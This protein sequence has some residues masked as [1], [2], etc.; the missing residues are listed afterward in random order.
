MKQVLLAAVLFSFFSCNNQ[1]PKTEAVAAVPAEAVASKAS[2]EFEGA[3]IDLMKKAVAAYEKKDFATLRSCFADSAMYMS[4]IWAMDSTQKG[5]LM[6]ENLA[7]EE[8]IL[9]DMEGLSMGTPIYE[10]VIT[11]DGS[12]YGHLWFRFTGKNKKTGKLYDVPVF[13]SFLIKDGKL[14]WEWNFYDTKK[15]D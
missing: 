13:S 1:A 14:A 8:K 4:N 6:S 2:V 12:R 11:P 3:D 10:V 5:I 7:M 15:F 9:A